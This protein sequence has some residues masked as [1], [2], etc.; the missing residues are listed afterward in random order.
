MTKLENPEFQ[1]IADS[2]FLTDVRAV[3]AKVAQDA[4]QPDFVIGIGR[5]GLVPAVYISHE[6]DVPMLSIDHSSKVADFA[7]DLL[8]KIAERSMTGTRLLFVDDINDSG[9]TIQEIRNLLKSGGCDELNLRFA[10]LIDNT[11]SKA[12]VD[13]FAQ[14]INRSDDKRWFVFPWEAVGS[15][16][17]IVAEARSV[18]E[19]FG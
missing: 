18:P 7:S 11:R 17:V 16:S 3:A 5:G 14:T 1:Y 2:T 9:G 15:S 19:R 10:V 4:W 8:G 13:Y 6:L 12:R